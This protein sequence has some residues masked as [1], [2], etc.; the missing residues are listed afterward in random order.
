MGE[1][2]AP[3]LGFCP[4]ASMGRARISGFQCAKRP[5]EWLAALASSRK[6]GPDG[7]LGDGSEK[8]TLQALASCARAWPLRRAQASGF[9][10]QG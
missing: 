4:H 9:L 2:S 3:D 5:P 1:G 6:G 8:V 10:S 7:V